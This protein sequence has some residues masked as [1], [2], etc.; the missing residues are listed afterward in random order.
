M[1]EREGLL[2]TVTDAVAVVDGVCD[3][4]VDALIVVLRLSVLVGDSDALVEAVGS[5]DGV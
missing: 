2:V 1:V 4:L 3:P 5:T